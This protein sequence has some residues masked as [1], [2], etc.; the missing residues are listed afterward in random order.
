MP[1]RFAPRVV[2]A[3]EGNDLYFDLW[4]GGRRV[5]NYDP[6]QQRWD[7]QRPFH[8]LVNERT[9]PGLRDKHTAP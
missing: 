5:G 3:V 6:Q 9:L 2:A 1:A 7:I 4:I 8:L